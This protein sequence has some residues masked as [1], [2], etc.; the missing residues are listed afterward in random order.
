MAVPGALHT[1]QLWYRHR[2]ILQMCLGCAGG[3]AALQIPLRGGINHI[4]L[5]PW[6]PE[7]PGNT[8]TALESPSS[9]SSPAPSS[10]TDRVCQTLTPTNT[11]HPNTQTFSGTETPERDLR[12]TSNSE[13]VPLMY[14]HNESW[15]TK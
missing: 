6:N 7:Y 9:G 14:L 8:Q 12:A 3:G 5:L 2:I 15:S 11:R 4:P 10:H 13:T 1:K